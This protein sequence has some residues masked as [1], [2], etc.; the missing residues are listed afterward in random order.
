MAIMI[1]G[2]Q[3]EI[4]LGA[5]GDQGGIQESWPEGQSARAVV[6]YQ[7]AFAD[8]YALMMGLRGGVFGGV[9]YLPHYYPHSPNLVCV[10][11]GEVK[12]TKP[13]FDPNIGFA[14]YELAIVPAEYGVPQFDMY[15]SLGG[16]NYT[17]PS[18]KAFTD[19]DW[20]LTVEALQPP[21]GA[22][23]WEGGP[24]AGKAVPDTSL[25]II[26]P[27]FEFTVRRSWLPYP[28]LSFFATH[29]G[30][31]NDDDVRI[32]DHIFPRGTLLLPGAQG[33]MGRDGSLE[34]RTGELVYTLVGNGPVQGGS[35]DPFTP[36]WNQFLADDGTWQYVNLLPTSPV[37]TKRPYRYSNFWDHLP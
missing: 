4:Y 14:T 5:D 3:A 33:G 27:R 35:G 10:G 20:Q 12:F 23:Y 31:V 2:V 30:S 36:E 17:D 37:S 28:P 18:G 11:I 13:R 16:S 1:G 34:G 7:C 9:I 25:G 26:R 21:T 19:T 15:P 24:K 32:S 29:G 22:Y 6:H 8:R